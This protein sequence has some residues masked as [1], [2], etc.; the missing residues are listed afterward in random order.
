MPILKISMDMG[1]SQQFKKK[2]KEAKEGYRYFLRLLR[3][4]HSKKCVLFLDNDLWTYGV[5]HLGEFCGASRSKVL[6]ICSSEMQFGTIKDLFQDDFKI[7]LIDKEMIKKI[8]SGYSLCDLS[9]KL[10]VVSVIEPYDTHARYM[11][12]RKNITPEEIV[13]IDVYKMNCIPNTI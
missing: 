12:G 6:V 4:E 13:C 9:T 11:I 8:L 3:K 10:T 5:M 7:R 1:E 2:L